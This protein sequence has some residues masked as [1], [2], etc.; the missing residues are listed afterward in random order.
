MSTDDLS[1]MNIRLRFLLSIFFVA[2]AGSAAHGQSFNRNRT[3]SE[4]ATSDPRVTAIDALRRLQA[5]VIIYRSLADFE[6]GG[7]L[8]RVPLPIFEA[9]LREVSAELESLLDRMPA[10]KAKLDLTNALDAYRDGVFWWRQID[11]PRVVNVSALAYAD[12]N[13][14]PAD[15]A[16]LSSIPY[17]VAIHW[18]QAEKYLRRAEREI[19]NR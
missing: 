16:F 13:H 19:S 5:D 18:R 4:P 11:Q 1:N 15:A 12:S 9:R 3:N 14:T 7:R 6:A 17:T 10:V 8:A 2:F